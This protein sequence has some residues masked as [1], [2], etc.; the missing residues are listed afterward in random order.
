M[1][2]RKVG[3]LGVLLVVMPC[4]AM[5]QLL[6]SGA[7]YNAPTSGTLVF[8]E[9]Y[10]SD[11]GK[12]GIGSWL[13][14]TS[15]TINPDSFTITLVNY[16]TY[17]QLFLPFDLGQVPAVV[18]IGIE[19]W[20]TIAG[21]DLLT[22]GFNFLTQTTGVKKGAGLKN[23]IADGGTLYSMKFG[24]GTVSV[25]LDEIS[26]IRFTTESEGEAT[27]AFYAWGNADSINELT[28]GNS[29]SGAANNSLV[30]NSPR[31]FTIDIAW[32]KIYQGVTDRSEPLTIASTTHPGD[33]NGDGMVNLADLQILGDN[34]QSTT[35][36]W[37]EADFTGDST[38][39]LADLQIIGDNWGYGTSPDI[40][41]DEAIELAGV[42]I[43]EPTGVVLLGLS[44][45]LLINRRKVAVH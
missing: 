35:A 33:A 14:T 23:T 39:N 18:D 5:A 9:D 40:T 10:G 6:P 21:P 28:I 41:L 19:Y 37:A 20:H 1:T 44:G 2:T 45:A 16:D 43:P 38:V 17:A 26:V 34:W 3:S 8:D 36:T 12:D 32:I 25:P 22:G 15:Y 30:I 13:G 7:T 31:D 24:S 29:G 11:A 42:T 4:L 27:N